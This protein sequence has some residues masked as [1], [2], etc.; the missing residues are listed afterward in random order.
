MGLVRQLVSEFGWTN[1]F[2]FFCHPWF[3]HN[4]LSNLVVNC[5]E[6][7]EID[8]SNWRELTNTATMAIAKAKNLER[9]WLVRCGLGAL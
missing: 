7:V 6:L 1:G 3:T 2:E 9:L 4:G 5:T 8:L